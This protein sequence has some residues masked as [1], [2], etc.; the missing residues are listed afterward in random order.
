VYF[1]SA[2]TDAGGRALVPNYSECMVA[3]LIAPTGFTFEGGAAFDQ[4]TVCEGDRISAVVTA[5]PTMGCGPM[6]AAGGSPLS[7]AASL[8]AVLGPGLALT[9]RRFAGS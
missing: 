4:R 8:A 7:S 6:P 2:V 9:R 5:D 3:T 1:N